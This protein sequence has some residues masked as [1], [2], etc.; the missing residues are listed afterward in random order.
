MRRKCRNHS[1]TCNAK[2]A[3]AAIQRNRTLAELAQKFNLHP[4]Q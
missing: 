4:N 2:V 3:L 1:S